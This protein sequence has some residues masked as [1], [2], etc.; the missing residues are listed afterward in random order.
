[1][2]TSVFT[3]YAQ[4]KIAKYIPVVGFDVGTGV[5]SLVGAGDGAGVGSLVGAGDG[6]R[7]GSLVGGSVSTAKTSAQSSSSSSFPTPI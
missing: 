1:M 2:D 4:Q 3:V 7:V 6:A 5:G